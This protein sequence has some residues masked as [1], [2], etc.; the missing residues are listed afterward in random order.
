MRAGRIE[1]RV[2]LR[3]SRSFERAGGSTWQVKTRSGEPLQLASSFA[4]GSE[5]GADGP[6]D[7]LDFLA[8]YDGEVL[9]LVPVNRVQRFN[10][11]QSATNLR[12]LELDAKI[13]SLAEHLGSYHV[14]HIEEE[15]GNADDR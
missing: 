7:E 10:I 3:R 6:A 5:N 14:A 12:F 2:D 13:D 1:H 4:P 9:R 8:G 11:E 15:P